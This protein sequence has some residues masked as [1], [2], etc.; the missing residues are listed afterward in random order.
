MASKDL[1]ARRRADEKFAKVQRRERD[2]MDGQRQLWQAEGDKLVRLRALR[3]AR[4]VADKQ[5][6]EKAPAGEQQRRRPKARVASGG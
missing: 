6:A 2:V 3:L 1:E 4:E 5:A